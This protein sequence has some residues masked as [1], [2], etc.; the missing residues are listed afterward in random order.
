MKKTF[1]ILLTLIGIL[2]FGQ[3]NKITE[4]DNQLK[5][6][7]T[8]T[9]LIESNFE[10]INESCKLKIWHKEKQ[11]FKIAQVKNVDYGE[12]KSKIYLVAN[13]PIKIVESESTYFF[14]TDSIAKIK[15][16]SID[17]EENFRAIAYIINWNKKQRKLMV[18]GKPTEEKNATYNRIKYIE[19][20][21]K[22]EKLLN[23]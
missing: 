20:F 2:V 9:E 14:L 21:R 3:E 5:S 7:D 13:K 12:I 18:S 4:I 8:D 1:T 6:I 16:Y 15:G 23:E 17:I 19:I 11:I 22:A 10:L